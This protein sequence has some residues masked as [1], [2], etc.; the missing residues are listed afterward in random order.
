MRTLLATV[1]LGTLIGTSAM[2]A[3]D[4]AR[5]RIAAPAEP[6][7]SWT[8]AY[9]GGSIGGRWS[10]VTWTTT[11]VQG[12]TSQVPPDPVTS[13]TGFDSSTF[14]GGGYLG[15]N[16]LFAPQWL[17]GVEGDLAWGN[18]GNTRGGIPGT[19]PSGPP[20]FANPSAAGI[21]S[22]RI[23]ED[24]DGSIRGR[25]GFLIAPT[26]L[27]YATGG[28]AWQSVELNATC[29]GLANNFPASW[30]GSV[31]RSESV[32]HTAT[33]FTVGGG[34]EANLAGNWLARAEY[35]Y[36]DY[37]TLNHT[38]FAFPDTF[39][40]SETLKTHTLSFGLAYKW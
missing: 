16:W 13:V 36:S 9:L 11:S 6:A 7:F 12:P 26:W 4:M 31:N 22:S 39:V 33:G 3:A 34:V 37:G 14:R 24:W 8:G 10:D 18:S 30:C 40:M 19:F 20:S 25:I 2:Q 1:V 21:D 5:P 28:A 17:I 38:F 23:S 32:S 35:R 27:A 29:N 15:Y